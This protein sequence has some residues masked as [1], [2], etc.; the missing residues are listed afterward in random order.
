MLNKKKTLGSLVAVT[1][2]LS[3]SKIAFAHSGAQSVVM[4]GDNVQRTHV[5]GI[6]DHYPR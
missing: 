5:N 4:F 2:A 1:L 6:S 3:A